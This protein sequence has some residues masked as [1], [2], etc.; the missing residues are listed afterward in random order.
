MNYGCELVNYLE[1][2]ERKGAAACSI[3]RVGAP[4]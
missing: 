1:E 4:N 3:V 2:D